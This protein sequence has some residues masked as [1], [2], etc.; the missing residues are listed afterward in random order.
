M[1]VIYCPFYALLRLNINSL[2]RPEKETDSKYVT[3]EHTS[4]FSQR[5]RKRERDTD[6]VAVA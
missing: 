1:A 4:H 3:D 5:E 6:G 2:M